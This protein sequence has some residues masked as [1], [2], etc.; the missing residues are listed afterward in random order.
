MTGNTVVEAAR[1][2]LGPVGVTLPVSFTRT[3]SA[4]EQ[5]SAG[6][7][8]EAAGVRAV[9]TNEVI[10]KDAFAHLAVLLAATERLTAGTCVAN[11]WARAPQTAHGAAAYL[12][13]AHPGRF[14]LGLG[15]G[16]PQQAQSVGR[17]FG[18]P[19]TTMRDYVAGMD[20]QTWPP[21]P[22]APYPR[23]LAANGPKLLALAADI[24]D[25]AL[26][27]ALPAEHTARARNTLGPDKLLVVGQSVVVDD[28]P[29]RARTT[30]R[31]VVRNWAT[32]PSFRATL[33][34]LGYA[35]S[36][37][38]EPSDRVVDAL[39]AHGRAESIAATIRAQL[40]AGADHVALLTPIGTEFASGIEQLV[41]IAP[42]L[43]E[44]G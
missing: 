3:P 24:A 21:A 44:I 22:E 20:E 31:E 12:A 42:A 39:V 8:L 19:V 4:R 7:R 33:I 34:E 27:A 37:I 38:D 14:V 28:D 13:Q 18:S 29:G 15:V 10:G 17:E 16:Y 23:I 30:A 36:E 2:A 32:R 6:R 41:S 35:A 40:D 26:P 5:R 11:I 25:G 1:S 9:W 43:T